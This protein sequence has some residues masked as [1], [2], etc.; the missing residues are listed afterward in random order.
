MVPSHS[1]RANGE[2]VVVVT[3][4]VVVVVGGGAAAVVVG[5]AAVVTGG[6][7]VTGEA[8]GVTVLLREHAPRS[9]TARA[10]SSRQFR[11]TLAA[12]RCRRSKTGYRLTP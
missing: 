1:G 10:T 4:K 7:V 6:A 3:G 5:M 2:M 11:F 8:V 12:Y 9:V